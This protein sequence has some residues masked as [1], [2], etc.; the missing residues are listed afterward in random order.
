MKAVNAELFAGQ[1]VFVGMDVHKNSWTVTELYGGNVTKT[2]SMKP[3]PLELAKH[4]NR[5]Y[6]GA[7]FKSVYEA[8]F[9]GFWIHRELIKLGIENIVVNP[10]DIPNKE[11]LYKNDVRDSKKLARKFS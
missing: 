8:G 5:E 3:D 9:C 2:Y 1:E 7:K 4:L 11:K 10:A 6:P